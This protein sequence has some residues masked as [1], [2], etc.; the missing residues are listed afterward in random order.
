MNWIM[1]SPGH[2]ARGATALVVA[3]V[4]LSGCDGLFEVDGDPHTIDAARPVALQ[5]M[6]VGATSDLFTSYD[7]KIVWGG[8]F[9]DEFVS[10]GTA[11]GIQAYDRRDVQGRAG[12][13][14]GRARS[15]GGGFYVNLQRATFVAN[16]A[17]ARIL[18]GEF[19][20]IADPANSP[21]Y[22][23]VSLFDGF[24]KTWIADLYCSAAF[25]GTGPEYSSTEVYELA[26]A[27]FTEA[28]NAAD[29]EEDVRYAA[30]VGR[31]RVRLILGD[32][33]GAVADAEQVPADF[34]YLAT[35]STNSF[36]ERNRV[37]FRTWDFANWSVAPAFRDLT[38]DDT[39]MP[40]PRVELAHDPRPAFDASQELYAPLKVPAASSPLRIATGDEARY[41]I[42]EV[43]GGETAVEI[44]NEIRARYG[45][46]VE[47]TPSGDDPNEVRDKLIDE[48]RRTLF[49][50]G[51]RMGDLRRYLDEYGLD[52]YQTSTPQNFPMG[53]ETCM[54]LPDS[55]RNTN[56]DI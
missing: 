31:A 16:Q 53:S 18:S 17:Q 42:A 38:I 56:P 13:G 34:E 24:A 44:I 2:R 45:I 21:E 14:G 30:L 52:F 1:Q 50:D 3:V 8:L 7:V 47:W 26:E 36:A 48:R 20:E 10:S 35:Y 19:G 25:N 49:L 55:E 32:D 43:E 46:D 22:A 41:I 12:G 28:L 39:G 15:I 29:A 27:E 37:H 11:P 6:L 9:G 33:A 4:A 51:V 54:Q 23:R 5:P 40:D